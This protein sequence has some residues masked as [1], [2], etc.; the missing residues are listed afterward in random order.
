MSFSWVGKGWAGFH[1]WG[2]GGLCSQPCCQGS[3]VTCLVCRCL[4]LGTSHLCL[5]LRLSSRLD[6]INLGGALCSGKQGAGGAGGITV[7]KDPDWLSTRCQA[8][9]T[10]LG[11]VVL[12]T[13]SLCESPCGLVQMQLLIRRPGLAWRLWPGLAWRL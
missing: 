10:A 3:T 5:D 8:E 9:P 13:I 7:R 12:S 4:T 11:R 2:R 6:V 1:N